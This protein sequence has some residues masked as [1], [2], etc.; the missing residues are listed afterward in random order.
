MDFW[1]R[2]D[3]FPVELAKVRVADVGLGEVDVGGDDPLIGGREV[4]LVAVESQFGEVGRCATEDL[5][6]RSGINITR[7][8]QGGTTDVGCANQVTSLEDDGVS[9]GVRCLID[10]PVVVRRVAVYAN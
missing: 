8:G 9:V 7:K 3:V 4:Q 10:G 6:G 1:K 2:V 5:N